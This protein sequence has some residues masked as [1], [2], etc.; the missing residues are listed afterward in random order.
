LL[1]LQPDNCTT[2]GTSTYSFLNSWRHYDEWEAINKNPGRNPRSFTP[3]QAN[4]N[5]IKADA[6]DYL[7]LSDNIKKPPVQ[8]S[9]IRYKMFAS[10]L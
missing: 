4:S 6:Y 10:V 5:L 9:F 2:A 3:F 8:L 1:N 7:A